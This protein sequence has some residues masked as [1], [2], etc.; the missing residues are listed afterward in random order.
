MK[1]T[2]KIYIVVFIWL[3]LTG[4]SFY[5]IFPKMSDSLLTLQKNH[6]DQIKE[7]NDLTAQIQSIHSMQ[8]DLEDLANAPVKPTDLFTSDVQLVHEIQYIESISKTTN[9]D[10][11]LTVTGSADDATAFAGAPGLFQVP[12]SIIL[13]G[14]FP[15]IVQFLHYFENSFFISPVNA[16][17]ITSNSA[18]AGGTGTTQ[19]SVKA[20]ILSNFLIRKIP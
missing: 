1:S 15:N 16:I 3:V 8:Q 11:K 18:A 17:D 12:Y 7:Y 13:T 20:T 9:N 14:T 10:L 5:F 19:S 6:Q 4:I 2:T